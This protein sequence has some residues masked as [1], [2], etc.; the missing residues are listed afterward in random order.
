MHSINGFLNSTYIWIIWYNSGLNPVGDDSFHCDWILN[1]CWF[2]PTMGHHGLLHPETYLRN[3]QD[4][5]PVNE[6]AFS[7]GPH[8]SND[9]RIGLWYSTYNELVTGANLNQLTSLGGLTLYRIHGTY[10]IH[11]TG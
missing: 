5:A 1:F 10:V 3:V 4:G 9:S 6:I 11:L 2:I 8:N 7:W